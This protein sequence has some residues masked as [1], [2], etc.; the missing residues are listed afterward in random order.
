MIRMW[1]KFSFRL[2]ISDFILLIFAPC[3]VHRGLV[4]ALL[5]GS[6]RLFSRTALRRRFFLGLGEAAAR[7]RGL[8]LVLL[9]ASLVAE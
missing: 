4:L 7:V 8:F 6:C 5:R 9:L 3:R 2:L 1:F